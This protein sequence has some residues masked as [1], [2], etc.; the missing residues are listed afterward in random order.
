GSGG[1]A[2]ADAGD[3]PDTR[4]VK[5]LRTTCN[6]FR[7]VA[8]IDHRGACRRA[9]SPEHASRVTIRVKRDIRLEHRGRTDEP[10]MPTEVDL[11]DGHYG[12]LDADPLVAVHRET[13]DEAHRERQTP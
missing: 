7:E 5:F 12:Q 13:Y 6:T 10:P 4:C 11:Y 1:H 8:A 9:G 2:V 3:F